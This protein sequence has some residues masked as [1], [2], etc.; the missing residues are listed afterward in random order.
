[1]TSLETNRYSTKYIGFQ[2]SYIATVS[3]EAELR[4]T[5]KVKFTYHLDPV[6]GSLQRTPQAKI[7]LLIQPDSANVFA[8]RCYFPERWLS[9]SRGGTSSFRTDFQKNISRWIFLGFAERSH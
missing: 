7:P 1:M 9:A 4:F 2:Q 3:H 5:E 6:L 8:A